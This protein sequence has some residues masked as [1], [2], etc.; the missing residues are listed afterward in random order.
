MAQQTSLCVFLAVSKGSPYVQICHTIS[1]HSVLFGVS[2]PYLNGK[3]VALVGETWAGN[4]P[5]MLELKNQ[6]VG[7]VQAKLTNRTEKDTFLAEL[8]IKQ[9]CIRLQPLRI[10]LLRYQHSC[11]Y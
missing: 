5:V 9:S 11:T 7:L 3:T 6:G 1:M 4:R 2:D 10:L 8:K